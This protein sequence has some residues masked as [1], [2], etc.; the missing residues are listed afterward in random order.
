MIESLGR[1]AE[2][3]LEGAYLQHLDHADLDTV[4]LIGAEIV[5]AVS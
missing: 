1:Y 2:A 4:R 3:G 5:P